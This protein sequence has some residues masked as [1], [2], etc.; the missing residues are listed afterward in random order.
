MKLKPPKLKKHP[1][2]R[3]F[4]KSST[5]LHESDKATK[6]VIDVN[7]NEE[8]VGFCGSDEVEKK[9]KEPRPM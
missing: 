2:M 7:I 9:A 8:A 6:E 5:D 3:L 4:K 1:K